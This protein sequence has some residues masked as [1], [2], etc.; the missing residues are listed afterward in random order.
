M[1]ELKTRK[2][3]ASVKA[4]LDAIED[5]QKRKDCR[6][7]A[8]MMKKATKQSPAMWGPSIVGFGSS[9]WRYANGKTIDWPVI[10]FSPRKQNLT[11][12][13]HPGFANAKKPLLE[14]LGPHKVSGGSCLYLK[15]LADVD[16]R[17]LETLIQQNV[18]ETR[19]ARRG[20]TTT[21][22]A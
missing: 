1:A 22:K 17:V 4:F 14:K 9:E 7:V 3:N 15:R 6:A 10:A 16:P 13:L 11:I 5:E 18:A 19:K 2:T 20:V 12:Y 8:A 21:R